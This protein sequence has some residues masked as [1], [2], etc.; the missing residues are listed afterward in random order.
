MW[1]ES[2]WCGSGRDVFI[3]IKVRQIINPT[4]SRKN[5]ISHT[6]F[7]CHFTPP[8]PAT[9]VNKH[10]PPSDHNTSYILRFPTRGF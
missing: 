5:P 1:A 8:P 3:Q 4:V 2:D 6:I 10:N 9:N 7:L